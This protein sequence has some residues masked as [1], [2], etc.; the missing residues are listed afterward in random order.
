MMLIS[1]G[2]SLVLVWGC[3]AIGL[4]GYLADVTRRYMYASRLFTH[5]QLDAL[6]TTQLD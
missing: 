3:V 5:M 1:L 2:L 6:A 4:W